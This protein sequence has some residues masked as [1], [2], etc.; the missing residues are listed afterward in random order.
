MILDPYRKQDRT[1]WPIRSIVSF[2]F[3]INLWISVTV[4]LFISLKNVLPTLLAP[5][6]ALESIH[7]DDDLSI[8]WLNHIVWSLTSI[9]ILSQLDTHHVKVENRQ[10]FAR[11]NE[12]HYLYCFVTYISLLILFPIIFCHLS[13]TSTQNNAAFTYLKKQYGVYVDWVIFNFLPNLTF[14]R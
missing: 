4:L 13:I 3:E 10:I 7:C 1:K 9:N 14:T 6:G 12:F 8:L 2:Y 11:F 5:D